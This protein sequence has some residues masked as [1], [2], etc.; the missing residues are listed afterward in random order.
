[1]DLLTKNLIPQRFPLLHVA[2]S[3]IVSS[4]LFLTDHDR[5]PTAASPFVP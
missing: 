4:G 2:P 1:M 5:W 3:G